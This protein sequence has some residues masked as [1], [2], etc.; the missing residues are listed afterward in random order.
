MGVVA[1]AVA[2]SCIV[3]PWHAASYDPE[4]VS[5]ALDILPVAAAALALDLNRRRKL[6]AGTQSDVEAN[7]ARYAT[8]GLTIL[9]LHTGSHS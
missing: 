8:V 7:L 5:F 6:Q 4:N 3:N 9:L 2:A 1:L